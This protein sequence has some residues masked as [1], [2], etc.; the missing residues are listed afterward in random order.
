MQVFSYTIFMKKLFLTLTL[1]LLLAGCFHKEAP[2][3]PPVSLGDQPAILP[4]ETLVVFAS[5]DKAN[6]FMTVGCET[7]LV[8]V[9]IS[10][11]DANLN[12]A[13]RTLLTTTDA[14]K[15]GNGLST[16]SVLAG[17]R[18][19]VDSIFDQEMNN[20]T[21]RIVDLKENK[22]VGI[23]GACDVPFAK[24]QITETARANSGNLP[25]VVRINGSVKEWECFGDASGKCGK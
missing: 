22:D 9:K 7:N 6:S 24:A 16:A 23:P 25:F 11:E 17:G 1:V 20:A 13:I 12:S 4:T 21:T 19:T 15:Y 2:T 5:D 3:P 8:K 10:T 14:T 18:F